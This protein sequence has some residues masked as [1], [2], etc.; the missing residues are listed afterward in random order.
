MK[1][2]AADCE[3]EHDLQVEGFSVE[4][5]NPAV[6]LLEFPLARPLQL[7]KIRICVEKSSLL[8]LQSLKLGC[9]ALQLLPSAYEG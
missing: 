9:G 8:Q 4:L 2:S 1:A 5:L 3:V 6:T 7:L